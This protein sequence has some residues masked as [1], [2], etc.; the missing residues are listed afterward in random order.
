MLR[1]CCNVTTTNYAVGAGTQLYSSGVGARMAPP[2][3]QQQLQM[4][5]RLPDAIAARVQQA[6]DMKAEEATKDMSSSPS[7]SSSVPSPGQR[8]TASSLEALRIQPVKDSYSLLHFTLR[9]TKSSTPTR[10]SFVFTCII[11]DDLLLLSG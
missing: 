9:L 1:C 2:F 3:S 8:D 4:L 6:I 5:L 10:V 11:L 7:S